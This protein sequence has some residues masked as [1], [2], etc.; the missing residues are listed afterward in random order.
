MYHFIFSLPLS[1]ANSW[2]AFGGRSMDFKSGM[3]WCRTAHGDYGP[4]VRD[5]NKTDKSNVI[6]NIFL[7]LLVPKFFW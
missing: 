2:N 5:M 6:E 3:R 4:T 1:E 7:D